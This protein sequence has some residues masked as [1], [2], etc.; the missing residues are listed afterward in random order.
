MHFAPFATTAR[1]GCD[2]PNRGVK[3]RS[4]LPEYLTVPETADLLRIAET[5]AY[6]LTLSG[7][8]PSVRIGRAIR[9][10]RFAL[11]S[12]LFRQ[13]LAEDEDQ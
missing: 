12:D 6:R 9:V 13:D 11:D 8:I 1:A 5:T 10:P 3:R 2:S 4:E 7:E